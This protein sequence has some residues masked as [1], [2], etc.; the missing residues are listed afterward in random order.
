MLAEQVGMF[1]P[2]LISTGGG[3]GNRNEISEDAE[4]SS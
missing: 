1:Y 4:W 3:K 2:D